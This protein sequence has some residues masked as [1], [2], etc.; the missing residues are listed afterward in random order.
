MARGTRR[1]RLRYR[2][3]PNPLYEPRRPKII[4]RRF[5]SSPTASV[6]CRLGPLSGEKLKYHP[7]WGSPL[8]YKAPQDNF[9]L[10][11]MQIDALQ[12]TNCRGEIS[13][14]FYTK[15]LIGGRQSHFGGCQFTFW[16]AP[17][18]ILEAKIVL[19]VIE[20][21]DPRKGWY[22]GFPRLRVANPPASYRSLSGPPGPKSGPGVPKS[23]EKVSKQSEKSG[24]SLE[25]VCSGKSLEKVP[26][27]H[28]RDFFRTFRTV[29][30]LFP[31]FLGPGP[32]RLF[33]DFFGISGPEGPRDSCSSREGS[34][35]LSAGFGFFDI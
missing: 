18:Y 19:G 11:K 6:K 33:S 3:D 10:Q 30:R 32:G 21:G 2:N 31:D 34:Q 1:Q 26:S 24:K 9:S 7:F 25:N 27:R 16:R 20:R 4:P 35:P 28:F 14:Y 22:F 17:I 23:L 13:V 5:L 8:F 12:N 15:L 29:S